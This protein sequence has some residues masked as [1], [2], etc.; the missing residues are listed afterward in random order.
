MS[1][2]FV[3][4]NKEALKYLAG[5]IKN[6][7][8]L[9]D[10]IN[11]T[12][13]ETSSTL[14]SVK[15]DELI[16]KVLDD[17]KSYT[18][19]VA[20]SLNNL[21]KKVV[22]VLPSVEDADANTMYLIKDASITDEDVYTQYLLIDGTMV[23]LGRTSGQFPITEY[24]VGKDYI[25][26]DLVLYKGVDNPT[27][28]I[29][30]CIAP[31]TATSTFDYSSWEITN[32]W[33]MD[34]N[35]NAGNTEEVYKLDITKPDGS[36]YTTANLK[37]SRGADGVILDNIGYYGLR[38]VDGRLKLYV[39]VVDASATDVDEQAPPFKLVDNNGTKHLLYTVG[40]TIQYES[41]NNL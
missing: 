20:S 25:L 40:G 33:K 4:M 12:S 24:E 7:T 9:S 1:K 16:R 8:R 19:N 13:L 2:E 21:K 23:A 22:T 26:G 14:S 30:R 35:G 34:I 39:N 29:Y 37:G 3:S 10:I 17:S 41:K 5:L 15:I 38:V 27:Y 6:A 28:N 11:D 18:D 36:I 31:H 32:G